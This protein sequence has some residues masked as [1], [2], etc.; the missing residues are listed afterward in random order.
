MNYKIRKVSKFLISLALPF[1]A[2]A[3]G[4]IFT[5]SSVGNWYQTLQKPFLN[6][7]DWIFGPVWTL[8]FFLM[9]CSLYL[10]WQSDREGKKKAYLIFGIQ[11]VLN[12]LWSVLFFGLQSPSIAF[13]EIIILW[14]FIIWNIAV[15]RKFSSAAAWFLVPYLLWVS[16]AAYLN[17]SIFRLN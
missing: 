13:A 16:F 9:G 4:S 10:V 7:P 14:V 15:F 17:F 1:L 8:L 11:L 12:I 3:I 5:A 2:A 6:P